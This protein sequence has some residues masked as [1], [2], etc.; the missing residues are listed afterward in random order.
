M[1]VLFLCRDIVEYLPLDH[2]C[3]VYSLA[4]FVVKTEAKGTER[5]P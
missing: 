2:T 1:G 3:I 5:T 4:V